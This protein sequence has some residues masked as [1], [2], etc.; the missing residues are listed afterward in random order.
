MFLLVRRGSRFQVGLSPFYFFFD[1][2]YLL[3]LF[4]TR[5]SCRRRACA[6]SADDAMGEGPPPPLFGATDG[7]RHSPRREGG[8]MSVSFAL[9]FS[10]LIELTDLYLRQF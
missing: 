9:S 6:P 2:A 10:L 8:E 1:E 3:S 5:P 4:L 7:F